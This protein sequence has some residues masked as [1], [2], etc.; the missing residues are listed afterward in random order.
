MRRFFLIG[1]FFSWISS[2]ATAEGLHVVV[3][4]N[5]GNPISGAVVTYIP[6]D[7]ETDAPAPDD[8]IIIGQ[9][10]LQFQPFTTLAP[11]GS[12]I[13]FRNED[14]VLHHAFS[15]SKTKRF[16]L[17]LF[18]NDEP[19]TVTFEKP[20]IVTVGCNIHDGMIAHIFLSDAS[21]V[22]QT[23]EAGAALI[24]G[25][26]ISKGQLMVWHP[27][28]R[29]RDNRLYQSVTIT[30]DMDQLTLTSKFRKGI[31]RSSDY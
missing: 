3:E 16:N 10:N 29:Q 21:F 26:P 27:L 11:V 23:D 12:T 13:S 5:R 7:V 17:K 25:A 9:K 30:D 22:A 15:F 28:M 20:G 8:T 31:T 2:A 1:L 4:D 6:E 14:S 18:G 24:K 19:Q